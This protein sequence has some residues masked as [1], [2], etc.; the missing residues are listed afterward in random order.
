M[1]KKLILY[2]LILLTF[3]HSCGSWEKTT[4]DL[5]E[6]AYKG[7]VKVKNQDSKVLIFHE[8]IKDSTGYYGVS[9]ASSNGL[10]GIDSTLSRPIYLKKDFAIANIIW[11]KLYDLD[12]I[13]GVLFDVTDSSILVVDYIKSPSTRNKQYY[14]DLQPIVKEYYAKNIVK[15]KIR[16]INQGGE[17]AGTGALVGGG[18]GFI[19]GFRVGLNDFDATVGLLFGAGAGAILAAGGAII[20]GALG[21]TKDHYI[22]NGNNSVF[23]KYQLELKSK[24]ATSN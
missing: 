11:V 4:V 18:L 20:G 8:I 9:K 21:S 17:A 22:I 7:K 19:I 12:E 2:Y 15:I 13:H 3:T 5:P 24:A 16:R 1:K 23:K 14:L 10:I 6:A